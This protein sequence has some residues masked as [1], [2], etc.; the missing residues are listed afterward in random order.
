M[1]DG[2]VHAVSVRGLCIRAEK[3]GKKVQVYRG[4][5]VANARSASEEMIGKVIE[6]PVLLQ[7]LR[8]NIGV[9][10]ALGLPAGPNS[11]LTIRLM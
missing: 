5:E 7:D 4:K 8:E 2:D 10:T 11:G 1:N 9:D 6:P 3:E